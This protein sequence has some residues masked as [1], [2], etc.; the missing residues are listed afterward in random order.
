[1]NL[2]TLLLFLFF[3]IS[4]RRRL[5]FLFVNFFSLFFH[6]DRFFD[7]F[8][9][10][11]LFDFTLPFNFFTFV[12]LFLDFFFV[13]CIRLFTFKLYPCVLLQLFKFFSFDVNFPL[14]CCNDMQ[15]IPKFLFSNTL[16]PFLFFLNPLF[17][18]S[19]FVFGR[20]NFVPDEFQETF[21]FHFVLR[22]VYFNC[23][24]ETIF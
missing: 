10:F 3:L 21:E 9:F 18:E 16:S 23:L 4:W 1:M 5:L 17:N 24:I 6:F 15:V 20:I 11:F 12:F 7:H 13:S 22:L 14:N 2:L 19:Y 8:R